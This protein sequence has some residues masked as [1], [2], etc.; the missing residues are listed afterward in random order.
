[1][2]LDELRLKASAMK[3]EADKE[4][5]LG[6]KREE[7][8]QGQL[9]AAQEEREKLKFQ[10]ETWR[11]EAAN[12]Q[13]ET[14][15]YKREAAVAVSEAASAK[16]KAELAEFEITKRETKLKALQSKQQADLDVKVAEKVADIKRDALEKVLEA[17]LK[18]AEREEKA[19]DMAREAAELKAKL[20]RKEADLEEGITTAVRARSEVTAAEGRAMAAEQRYATERKDITRIQLEWAIQKEKDEHDKTAATMEAIEAE[21]NKLERNLLKANSETAAWRQ[22]AG[23]LEMELMTV[24]KVKDE[25]VYVATKAERKCAE[26]TS[27]LSGVQEQALQEQQA[28]IVATVHVAI[29]L[30]ELKKM[31]LSLEEEQLVAESVMDELSRLLAERDGITVEAAARSVRQLAVQRALEMAKERQAELEKLTVPGEGGKK[32]PREKGEK[33]SKAEARLDASKAKIAQ[34]PVSPAP[35]VRS[36]LDKGAGGVGVAMVMPSATDKGSANPESQGQPV[37]ADATSKGESKGEGEGDSSPSRMKRLSHKTMADK[38]EGP[39][40]TRGGQGRSTKASGGSSGKAGGSKTKGAAKGGSGAKN[41]I[42]SNTTSSTSS[43]KNTERAEPAAVHVQPVLASVR[44]A[45][46]EQQV[47]VAGKAAKSRGH[48][49]QSR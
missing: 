29:G 16:S 1:M 15:E 25:A 31:E 4:R 37:L 26:A 9:K 32:P 19:A 30:S 48:P 38:P 43:P 49:S 40:S 5:A 18:A 14:A 7:R 41:G 11:T 22:K 34:A 35:V 36:P 17:K 44:E 24:G 2:A 47:A 8:L 3:Q 46:L 20:A 23:A 39:E 45:L 27:A 13:R 42:L 21:K 28:K 12:A 33:K 6:E 10:L